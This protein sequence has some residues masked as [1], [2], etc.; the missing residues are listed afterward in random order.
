MDGDDV[1]NSGIKHE[2]FLNDVWTAKDQQ[3][4]SSS[5]T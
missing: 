5:S 2:V 3:R 4:D 1:V